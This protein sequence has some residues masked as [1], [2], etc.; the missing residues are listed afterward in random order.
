MAMTLLES[1]LRQS[2]T[3]IP[4][5]VEA[6]RE[7]HEGR[8]A[9]KERHGGLDPARPAAAAP[10]PQATESPAAEL[11]KARD[12]LASAARFGSGA[13][14]DLHQY[15]ELRDGVER[16]E[17]DARRHSELV[18]RLTRRRIAP[19]RGAFYQETLYLRCQRGGR[20]GGRFRCENWRTR[21]TSVIAYCFPFVADG[22]ELPA[23][24]AV[25]VHP[26][27]F[28]L[29]AGESAVVRIEL[30]LAEWA[31]LQLGALAT[32]V[33]LLMDDKIALKLWIEVDV[34]ESD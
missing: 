8:C 20:T 17:R 10:V 2:E 19:E 27:T 28:S 31:S 6:L 11:A 34:Y 29:E 1:L 7:I 30:D 33:D 13:V 24:P 32:S 22:R 5:I 18:D 26:E 15:R 4:Q 12:D 9:Q 16:M 14:D 23:G 21:R 25:T 3:S